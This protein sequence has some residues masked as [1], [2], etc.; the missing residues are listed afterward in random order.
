[1]RK[2]V[3][4]F[5][6]SSGLIIFSCKS[7]T[8]RNDDEQASFSSDNS[9]SNPTGEVARTNNMINPDQPGSNEQVQNIP[10]TKIKFKVDSYDFG[11]VMEGEQVDYDYEFVNSGDEPLILSKV[12]ASCGCTTPSWPR[13]NIEPGK[14]GKIHAKFDTKGRGRV[15]GSRQD[16][17][18][19]VVGNFEGSPLKLKLFGLVDKEEI[20]E[21]KIATPIKVK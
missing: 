3:L 18:I 12:T 8:V 13:E 9:Q 20:T 19:T 6:I 5:L 4:F 16:K 2:I 1:M 21:Q 15:G 14:S 7:D 11:K 10:Q 17:T